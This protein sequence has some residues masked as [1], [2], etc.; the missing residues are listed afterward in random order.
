MPLISSLSLHIEFEGI[1]KYFKFHKLGLLIFSLI[2]YFSL[3]S[4]IFI[5]HY[6]TSL[7]DLFSF[8][9]SL[10]L[11]FTHGLFINKKIF[12]IV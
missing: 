10:S 12:N 2:N 3:Y 6:Y 7:Y 8:L 9:T 11:Q 5:L 4:N 1:L